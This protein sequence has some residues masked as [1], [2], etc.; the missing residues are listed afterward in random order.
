[1]N[2]KLG[3]G[4]LVELDV[5][6]GGDGSP[7]FVLGVRKSGSSIMNSICTTLAAANRYRFVDV[8]G[9]FFARNVRADVWR[10]DPALPAIVKPGNMYGGFREMPLIFRQSA[11]FASARKIL[12]IRD[13]RDALVSEYFSNA[14][15]HS[16]PQKGTGSDVRDLMEELR[17]RSLTYDID[18]IVVDRARPM[19]NT[20]MEYRYLLNDSKIRIFKYEDVIRAKRR[21]IEDILSFLGWSCAASLPDQILGWADVIPAK[22][23][24]RAFVRKVTP[25]DYREKLKPDTIVAIENI[26]TP[27]LS[28]FG[29]APSQN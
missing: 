1:M 13:P 7:I 2:L 22:E 17:A 24:P 16:I 12:L 28:L 8:G 23:D 29:Y 4:V 27:A 9:T 3:N 15:S 19:L 5:A 20:I 26:L 10:R 14:Y 11:D 21:W 18:K 25:G 6:S